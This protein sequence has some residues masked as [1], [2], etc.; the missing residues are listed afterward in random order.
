MNKKINFLGWIK[1]LWFNLA[2]SI[3]FKK[4]N[5]IRKAN[6]KRG[7]KSWKTFLWIFIFL[8]YSVRPFKTR[9]QRKRFAKPKKII[10]TVFIRKFFYYITLKKFPQSDLIIVDPLNAENNVGKNTRQ[11]NNIKLAFMIGFI[12]S[13]EECECGCH[14]QFHN[15]VQCRDIE[16][17]ILKRIFNA[18]KRFTP[19]SL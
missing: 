11:F 9:S 18:V 10:R 14:Y 2:N 3:F 7:W 13:K 16:H 5:R 6:K 4:A 15:S 8:W 12:A 17:C 1:F 19:D